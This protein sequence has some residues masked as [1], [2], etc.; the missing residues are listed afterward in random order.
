VGRVKNKC[1]VEWCNRIE[2]S[3]GL[4]CTHYTRQR[5]GKDLNDPVQ[6]HVANEGLPCSINGCDRMAKFKTMCPMHYQRAKMGMDMHKPRVVKGINEGKCTVPG[7]ERGQQNSGMCTMHY[8]R[9]HLGLNISMD[10]PKQRGCGPGNSIPAEERFWS[11]VVKGSPD[12]CWEWIGGKDDDGYGSMTIDG[13]TCRA[14]RFSLSLSGVSLG[15][16]DLACHTCDNPPCVNPAHLFKGTQV[17]NMADMDRKGRRVIARGERSGVAKLNND[18][19]LEIRRLSSLGMKGVDIAR[20]IGTTEMTVSDVL[21]RK[22]W[23]HLP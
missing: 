7:C 11:K 8:Q 14:A 2:H 17:D 19:V 6:I 1:S 23:K 15:P 21:R 4:C 3:R 5:I 9:K 10:A 20:I 18:K 13:K 22:S 16:N 12:E